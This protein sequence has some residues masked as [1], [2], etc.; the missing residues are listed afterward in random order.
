MTATAVRSGKHG[1]KSSLLLAGLTAILA[2]ACATAPAAV[3]AAP[4]LAVRIE[5]ATSRPPFHRAFW[6]ILMEE[7]DGRVLYAQN[8][9]KLSIPASNRKLFA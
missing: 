6:S 2:S 4:T 5:S 3:P 1:V 7:D 9:G 8:E